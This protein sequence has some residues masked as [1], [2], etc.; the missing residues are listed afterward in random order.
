MYAY[1]RNIAQLDRV[2]RLHRKCHWF[3]SNYSYHYGAIAQ[4]VEQETENLCVGGASPPG[5]TILKIIYTYSL[6]DKANGYEPLDLSSIL[7]RC[8]NIFFT[9][10]VCRTMVSPLRCGRGHLGSIPSRHTNFE[11]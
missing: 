4:I 6:M 5:S 2:L 7:S 3:K 1:H 8:T 11:N 9:D 10:G